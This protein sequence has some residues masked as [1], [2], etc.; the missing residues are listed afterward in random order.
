[1]FSLV[2]VTAPLACHLGDSDSHK[3]SPI[4]PISLRLLTASAIYPSILPLLFRVSLIF[5]FKYYWYSSGPILLLPT[6]QCSSNPFAPLLFRYPT[7]TTILTIMPVDDSTLVCDLDI[8]ILTVILAFSLFNIPRALVYIANNR[9]EVFHGYFLRSATQFRTY[10]SPSGMALQ[11]QE[12]GRLEY[13]TP[14]LESAAPLK[15]PWHFPMCFSLRHPAASFMQYRVLENYTIVQVVLMVGYTAAVFYAAFDGSN[16][17]SN[18]DHLGWV[19]ASQIPF[20]YAFATKNNVIGLLV[21]VGYEKV[22]IYVKS[23]QT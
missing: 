3:R 7:K 9:S 18:P 15:Q 8:F 23:I 1:M 2:W 19:I 10:R 13:S 21:G 20:V 5:G 6:H 16:P 22:R 4:T 11:S 17:F 14:T 12:K